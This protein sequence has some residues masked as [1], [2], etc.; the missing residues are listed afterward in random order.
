[1]SPT[2]QLM[3]G[4]CLE[5]L[6]KLPDNSVDM[7]LT[8]P[9]YGTTHAKWDCA[10]NWADWWP[11]LRRVC[12]DNAAIVMFAAGR[13]TFTLVASNLSD[14]RYRYIW[15]KTQGRPAGFLNAGRRPLQGFEDV[16]LFYRRQPTYNP[17]MR[18]GKPYLSKN[19]SCSHI[20]NWS[21]AQEDKKRER[22]WMGG[23]RFPLDVI[24][25][26]PLTKRIHSSQ[27]PQ[28]LLSFFIKTYSNAGDVVLDPFMGS[29]SCAIAC[30]ALGRSFIGMERDAEI[31][32]RAAQWV[33]STKEQSELLPIAAR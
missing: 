21:N 4:D 22:K 13:F 25:V 12:K 32:E 26:K 20:Y 33:D 9:P 29:G 30:R 15:D 6:A 17:Q 18:P 2:M 24:T 1:M 16:C 11:E 31:Y 3:R 19:A 27:K 7:V 8:D 5:L 23:G 14:F 10:I 28:E